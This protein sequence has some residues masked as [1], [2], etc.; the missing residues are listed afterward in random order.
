VCGVPCG[1]QEA[2]LLKDHK[3]E[4]GYGSSTFQI[5]PGG[6][7]FQKLAMIAFHSFGYKTIE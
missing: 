2:L 7:L 4:M 3:V 5:K 6:C 1:F